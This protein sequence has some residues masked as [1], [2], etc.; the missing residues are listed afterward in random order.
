[1]TW[2]KLDEEHHKGISHEDGV[3]SWCDHTRQLAKDGYY[4]HLITEETNGENNA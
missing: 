3:C 2:Q 1:M 4:D